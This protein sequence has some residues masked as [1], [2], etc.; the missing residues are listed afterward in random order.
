MTKNKLIVLILFCTVLCTGGFLFHTYEQNVEKERLTKRKQL[1]RNSHNSAVTKIKSAVGSY[2]FIVAGVKSYT[3]MLP[4]PPNDYQLKEYIYD[5][6][7]KIDF[8]DSVL[9]SFL[10]TNHQFTYTIGPNKTDPFGLQGFNISW[11]RDEQEIRTLDS[12]MNVDHIS[13]LPPINLVEG[14]PAFPFCFNLKNKKGRVV[15]YIAAVLNTKY[16]INQVYSAETDPNVFHRFVYQ[17]DIDFTDVAVYDK[18]TIFNEN[19]DSL[20]YINVGLSPDQFIYTEQEI[21]NQ[22]FKLGTSLR[23]MNEYTSTFYLPYYIIGALI[24]LVLLLVI[25]MAPKRN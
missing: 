25:L 14:W 15:G 18:S 7:N 5:F 16:L 22:R 9:L 1:I 2:F 23:D 24:L 21:Y 12:V 19:Y 8:K 20:Y 13:L 6:T 4:E 10:D 17:D 11:F 3:Q